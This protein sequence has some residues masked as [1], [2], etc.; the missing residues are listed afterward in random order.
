[1]KIL[2]SVTRRGFN[3]GTAGWFTITSPRPWFAASRLPKASRYLSEEFQNI[4]DPTAPSHPSDIQAGP[5]AAM[6]PRIMA[7]N[8][9]ARHPMRQMLIV[10]SAIAI[11]LVLLYWISNPR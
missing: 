4:G 11:T 1:M 7:I 2:R 10:L 6:P 5:V 9:D 8:S 3:V